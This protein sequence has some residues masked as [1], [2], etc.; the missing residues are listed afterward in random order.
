MVVPNRHVG[1]LAAATGDELVELME[2]TRTA[3]LALTEAYAPHGM[4]VGLNLG[5]SAGAGIVD[6]LHI[7]VVPRWDADTNFMSVVGSVRVVPEEIEQTATR[8]RPIFERLARG[9]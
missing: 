7:H 1:T 2:L 5:R 9:A 4:N 3:E 6:H 8:L